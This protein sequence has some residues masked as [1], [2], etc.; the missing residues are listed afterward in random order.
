MAKILLVEDEEAVSRSIK[1][2]L[3]LE[4]HIVDVVPDGTQGLDW[5][6]LSF[7]DLA[8]LDW[9][10]PG[11]SGIEI[12]QKFRSQGGTVPILVLT[13]RNRVGERRAGLDAGA[14][15][16]LC[17]PFDLE[18]LSA[19]V[20]ALLRRSP[21]TENEKI[22]LGPLTLDRRQCAVW[23]DGRNVPLKRMEF[24]LLELFMRR[25]NHVFSVEALVD[26]LWSSS[27]EATSGTVR[28]HIQRLRMALGSEDDPCPIE[29][30][31]GQGYVFRYES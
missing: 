21:N 5:L 6:T 29:T 16:Y 25:P 1:E 7:Y 15:D 13:A 26:Q 14:E 10:L 24:R 20:R 3:E 12:C 4:N 18:E 27:T 8:I 9:N 22:S 28:T 2:W 11:L 31:Q 23:K 30:V 17:K 19:R